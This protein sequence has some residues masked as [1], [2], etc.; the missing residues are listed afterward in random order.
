MWQRQP[1]ISPVC[2]KQSS[3]LWHKSTFFGIDYLAWKSFE[4][5]Y[6]DKPASI[7]TQ[8]PFNNQC[9]QNNIPFTS[10]MIN[11]VSS[12][13]PRNAVQQGLLLRYDIR[14]TIFKAN[15]EGFDSQPEQQK[16]KWVLGGPCRCYFKKLLNNISTCS[17]TE[18]IKR[19]RVDHIKSIELILSK[20]KDWYLRRSH[21]N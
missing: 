7:Y 16:I 1:W 17:S 3:Q 5:T 2:W 8:D 10:Q 12:V 11:K 4:N 9:M 6:Q 18:K 14:N 20:K 13:A 15:H 21:E 19:K